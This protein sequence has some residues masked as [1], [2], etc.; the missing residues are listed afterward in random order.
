MSKEA[1][2]ERIISDAQASAEAAIADAQN[3][4]AQIVAEAE[5]GA[6]RDKKGTQAYI[7]ERRKAILDGKSATARL[8]SAKV[9]LAEKRRVIDT[10]Y[11]HALEKL[12][13]LPQ[14]DAVKLAESL[15]L[16]YAEDGDEIVFA[17]N[18]QYKAQVLKLS[19]ISEK[20]LK[21][22]GKTAD[23]DGGF[24]L[25]GKNSDKDLSYGALLA[26]DREERQSEIAAKLFAN[27]DANA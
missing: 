18:F 22:T 21:N 5:T 23:I 12:K 17:A 9:L 15:L 1:I 19:V 8:D 26:L 3:K 10:V 14:K 16:N 20:N 4:S 6:E 25:V 11:A 24:V 27:G 7:A 13:A 2:L